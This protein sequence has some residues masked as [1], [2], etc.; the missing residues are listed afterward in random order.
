MGLTLGDSDYFPPGVSS[1]DPHFNEDTCPEC[2]E[3][4]GDDV[5]CPEC[6]AVLDPE[7]AA[8][9]RADYLHDLAKDMELE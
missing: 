5:F 9:A 3:D 4:I 2:G 7:E 1:S 6:G 8:Y